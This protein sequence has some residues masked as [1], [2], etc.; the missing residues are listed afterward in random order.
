MPK[1][2][3]DD[4]G[5]SDLDTIGTAHRE[6]AAHSSTLLAAVEGGESVEVIFDAYQNMAN[7]LR[8]HFDEEEAILNQHRDIPEIAD[9]LEKHR[10]NHASFKDLL[11]YTEQQFE[12]YRVSGKVPGAAELLPREYLVE[13]KGVDKDMHALLKKHGLT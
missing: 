4:V 3:V 6:I 9:H 7:A 2:T 5:L 12:V 8:A 1:Y 11:I 10:E 13:L